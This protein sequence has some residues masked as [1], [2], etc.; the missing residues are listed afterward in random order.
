MYDSAREMKDSNP[1]RSPE[2]RGIADVKKLVRLPDGAYRIPRITRYSDLPD[3]LK[4]VPPDATCVIADKQDP[5][6][7]FTI[8]LV[9]L[10]EG[11]RRELLG[12][13][14]LEK[15]ESRSLPERA[16]P[17]SGAKSIDKA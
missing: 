5:K 2:I 14:R 6:C 7:S 16:D 9:P 12:G 4:I 10:A 3:W 11:E 13:W 1:E 15:V 17:Q 8:R